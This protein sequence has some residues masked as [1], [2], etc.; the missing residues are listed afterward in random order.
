MTW[1]KNLLLRKNNLRPSDFGILLDSEGSPALAGLS[2][3]LNKEK[4]EK[5]RY[6]TWY[7]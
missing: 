6:D 4:Y 5:R 3:F 7:D 1:Q 2:F